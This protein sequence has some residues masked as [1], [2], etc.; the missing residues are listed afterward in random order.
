M[1]VHKLGRADVAL[2][3]WTSS[4]CL[5]LGVGLSHRRGDPQVAGHRGWRRWTALVLREAERQRL[6]SVMCLLRP[7]QPGGEQALG[8][9]A[10]SSKQ[11]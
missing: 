10:S 9:G 2:P 6:R 3:V 8:L 1:G 5:D 7:P 11:Q 4:D